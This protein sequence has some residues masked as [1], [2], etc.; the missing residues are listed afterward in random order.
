MGIAIAHVCASN[1]EASDG[2]HQGSHGGSLFPILFSLVEY[3]NDQCHYINLYRAFYGT[4]DDAHHVAEYRSL[5]NDTTSWHSFQGSL[6]WKAAAGVTHW[7]ILHRFESLHVLAWT[8]TAY[9]CYTFLCTLLL[10]CVILVKR[11]FL[12]WHLLQ[13]FTVFRD[14]RG[15]EHRSIWQ[16]PLPRECHFSREWCESKYQ[17]S[18]WCLDRALILL[19]LVTSDAR[20]QFLYF[21]HNWCI[22]VW[23]PTLGKFN[24][25]QSDFAWVEHELR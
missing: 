24:I 3:D 22:S 13:C 19:I 15:W 14:W 17:F 23:L 9:C 6:K 21:C 12:I 10:V 1:H 16:L 25:K 18:E 20:V 11:N 2:A 5:R 4:F 8:V 7:Q